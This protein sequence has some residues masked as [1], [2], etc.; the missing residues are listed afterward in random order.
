MVAMVELQLDN[1]NESVPREL[2]LSF[3]I[4]TV[5]LVS[6]HLLALMISTCILPYV[7]AVAANQDATIEEIHESPHIRMSAFVEIAWTL[8]NVFGIFLFLLEVI[9]ICWV[10][11]WSLEGPN[12]ESGRNAAWV[13][14]L[15][16]IP[17]IVIFVAFAVHFYRK[18]TTHRVERAET[19][20][21]DL[22]NV[23]NDLDSHLESAQ[24]TLSVHAFYN[25]CNS[26]RDSGES[27]PLT[28]V[29][30]SN[31]VLMV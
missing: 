28:G 22:E 29:R 24:K 13:A 23:V 19:H 3:T 31:P 15:V 9:V 6:T 16:L 17:I 18:L 30:E 27:Q 20:L 4:C 25:V 7:D 11:F 26:S 12:N 14:T 1:K 21:K 10:R 2:L 8:S 5:L